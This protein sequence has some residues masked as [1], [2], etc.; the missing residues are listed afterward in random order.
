MG[1]IFR[2]DSRSEVRNNL[3]TPDHKLAAKVFPPERE[4]HRL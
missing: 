3:W 2:A 1:S 4:A